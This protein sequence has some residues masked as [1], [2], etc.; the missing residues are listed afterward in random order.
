MSKISLIDD[1]K[2]VKPITQPFHEN[3]EEKYKKKKYECSICCSRF[4]VLK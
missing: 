2:N 4:A 3:A 1:E